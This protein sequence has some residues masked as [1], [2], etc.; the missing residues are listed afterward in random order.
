MLETRKQKVFDRRIIFLSLALAVI[1]PLLLPVGVP[2]KVSQPVRDFYDK[3]EKLPAE[4][5]ILLSCDYDPA[6]K[7]EVYPMNLAILRHLFRRNMKVVSFSLWE[8]GPP[9]AERALKIVAEEYGQI[10]GSDYVNLGFKEGREA[11]MVA[12]GENI[13][14]TFP[15]DYYRTPIDSISLLHDVKDYGDFQ[16][17]ISLT[18]G[19]PGGREYA[20]YVQP[21]FDIPLV[22]AV[23]ATGVPFLMPYYQSNQISGLVTGIIG[24]AEYEELIG[25]PGWAKRIMDPLTIGHLMIIVFIVL[26][27]VLYWVHRGSRESR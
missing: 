20:K 17:L 3:I 18:A 15:T 9:M 1:I 5:R 16:L 6:A 22:C 23:V 10:Y 12:M 19:Y 25:A 26:G 11:T 4:A 14:N 21:R 8:G 13:R 24:G 2:M 7:A 27:N